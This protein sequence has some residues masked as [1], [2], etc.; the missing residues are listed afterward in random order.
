[1]VLNL[2]D[3]NHSSL[4]VD[5]KLF[6]LDT[7][8]EI[9]DVYLKGGDIDNH[10]SYKNGRWHLNDT[11]FLDQ[12]MRDVFFSVI[13][14]VEIRKPVPLS[15]ADSLSNLLSKEGILVSIKFG[16]ELI[17]EYRVLGNQAKEITWMMLEEDGLP[18]HVHLPG[19]QSYV[20]GIFEVPVQD[21]RSRFVFNANFALLT[22]IEVEYP[23]ANDKLTLEYKDQFFSI[24]GIETD[25]LKI[26]QFLDQL[27][28]LQA[29]RF[30]DQQSEADV[31]YAYITLFK[32]S[33]DKEMITFFKKEDSDRFIVARLDDG[34]Y[35]EFDFK[36]IE[37]VFQSS[38]SLY[39]R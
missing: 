14:Q 19:Y 39:K 28:Y 27:A 21:W 7:Q 30:L 18:Y 15:K 3:E 25:S 32:S 1:M 11:L 29:D 33:G 20:A 10:F 2:F 9:T 24:P 8:Q 31:V 26:T 35:C 37:G 17:N 13:S 22:K 5:R 36:R 6:Q 4:N 16:E 23:A 34:S 12:S 38:S